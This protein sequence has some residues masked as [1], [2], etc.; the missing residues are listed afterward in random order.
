MNMHWRLAIPLTCL[1]GFAAGMTAA[2]AQA[3]APT[4]RAVIAPDELKWMPAPPVLPKGVQ[5]AVLSGN[6][7]AE[8]FSVVRLKI[9]PHTT[10]LRPYRPLPQ[11]ESVHLILHRLRRA[12]EPVRDL[13]GF[14]VRVQLAQ[15]RHLPGGP[16]RRIIRYQFRNRQQRMA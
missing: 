4:D 1:L 10:H 12:P 14:V 2:M 9:P 3:P 6:P 5:I 11:P 16:E 7:F 8:G 13:P 15:G